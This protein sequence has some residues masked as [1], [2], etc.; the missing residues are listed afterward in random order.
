MSALVGVFYF[1]DRIKGLFTNVEEVE[2]SDTEQTL[3]DLL[4]PEN[5]AN[6]LDSKYSVNKI[7]CIGV[8]S[9]IMLTEFYKI[10]I[11]IENNQDFNILEINSSI[12]YLTPQEFFSYENFVVDPCDT[13]KKFVSY[14][15]QF[16]KLWDNPSNWFRT[17]QYQLTAY[18][19]AVDEILQSLISF[20]EG[21]Q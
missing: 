19:K 14:H 10:I 9:Y 5:F 6:S 16:T 12:N 15:K 3:A 11:A 8:N 20:E 13:V 7:K 17:K 21:E 4:I 2:I 1:I 18:K